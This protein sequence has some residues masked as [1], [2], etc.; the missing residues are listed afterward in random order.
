M[1]FIL[2][3]SAYGT[4]FLTG[5]MTN[6]EVS[7]ELSIIMVSTEEVTVTIESP[8]PGAGIT[9]TFTDIYKHTFPIG[10]QHTDTTGSEDK[11]V[12]ISS[13][14]PIALFASNYYPDSAGAHLVFP[15]TVISKNYFVSTF[16]SNTEEFLIVGTDDSTV[17]TIDIPSQ[18]QITINIDRFV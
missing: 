7:D 1:Y 2:E 17:V 15:N 5:F 8:Y 3:L 4:T 18:S 14:K 10:L 6:N 9:V 11:G 12:S 13:T 16:P